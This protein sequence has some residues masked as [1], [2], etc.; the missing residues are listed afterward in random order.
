MENGDDGDTA[1][2]LETVEDALKFVGDAFLVLPVE[3]AQR[4]CTLLGVSPDEP[5][6]PVVSWRDGDE[7]WEK[8]GLAG[9][10]GPGQGIESVALSY[11][12]ARGLGID[13]PPGLAFKGDHLTIAKQASANMAAIREWRLERGVQGP[14]EQPGRLIPTGWGTYPLHDEMLVGST[15]TQP[16]LDLLL[17]HGSFADHPIRSASGAAILTYRVIWKGR[18]EGHP[19]FGNYAIAEHNTESRQRKIL[20]IRGSF[21]QI[22]EEFFI[23]LATWYWLQMEGKWQEPT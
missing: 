13:P 15:R 17:A 16:E 19:A 1:Y 20:A 18:V 6:P 2:T 4:V 5:G 3:V 14:A 7:A 9:R 23:D 12:V 21:E 10:K 11:Y 8:C 22:R